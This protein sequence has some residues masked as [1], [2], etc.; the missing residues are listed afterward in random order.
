MLSNHPITRPYVQGNTQ[1]GRA[2]PAFLCAYERP[3][4][5][6]AGNARPTQHDKAPIARYPKS[7][8]LRLTTGGIIGFLA[9]T[10]PSAAV[11]GTIG[12]Y[13][14]SEIISL[15]VG[16]GPID[17][18]S[19]GRIVTLIGAEVHTETGLGSRQFSQL[20]TLPDADLPGFG[21]AFIRVSPKG[22]RLAVGNNGGDKFGNFQVGIFDAK[23]LFG[24]W[25]SASH[26]DAAW[27]NETQL[28]LTAGD[29]GNPGVVTI[30]DTTSP[31]PLNPINPIVI[32]NI[33]GASAGIAFD[34]R[35][36]LFTGNGFATSGPSGTGTV[37]FF[38]KAA[39]VAA[40]GGG[41]VL[42]FEFDGTLIV[43]VLS[44]APLGFDSFGN[45]FAGGGDFSSSDVDNAALVS[46]S[47]VAGA[48]MGLGPADPNDPLQVRRL[49]PDTLNFNFYSAN[50]N[51]VSD[52]LYVH[53]L[54]L[55]P[56]VY[57]YRVV[58]VPADS[59]FAAQVIDYSPAPG[60]FVQNEAFNDPA[61]AL[62]PPA[63]GGTSAANNSSVV[64]LGGFGGSITLAFDHTV[65]DDRA[66]PLGLDA[67]V[68]G[69]AFWIDGNAN[70]HWAE[71]GVIEICRDLNGNR[72]PDE[73]EPWYLMAGSHITDLQQQYETQT[74]DD[75]I[76]DST[77]PP[78]NPGWIPPKRFGTWQT[79]GFR[80]PPEIF[81]VVVLENP[82]GPGAEEEGIYGYADF[83]PSLILGD[84]DADD[85][86]D[87]E[88]VTPEAFYTN[89]DDPFTVGIR[90]GS[91]GGDAFDIAWAVDPGTGEP[92][93]LD[94]FDFIRITTA[95]NS[96][97]IF[98]ESSTEV[99]AVADVEP[100]L[101][102]D[103]DA[104][105][106]VDLRDFDVFNV[107]VSVNDSQ[108]LPARCR[109]MDFNGDENVDLNDFGA[110]QRVFTGAR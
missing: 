72:K 17:V 63:G 89:P 80:L 62:G 19:D 24:T 32:D 1:V 50:F 84:L 78:S 22:T 68:F 15:P 93:D 98:G 86:V 23:T 82:N 2:V 76:A 95:V 101:M 64:T 38:D 9:V 49:D 35:G 44:A 18:L 67:I 37:K 6:A 59:P 40:L 57:V 105:G 31:D 29:F 4:A 107:C 39:W 21:A 106:A 69:N 90:P 94:G 52:E 110:F 26:F 48:I 55:A 43:D 30:L 16:A 14:L 104:D 33:G 20:G 73:N 53:D 56:T 58:T 54:F 36:N 81:D 60:Q 61:K 8:L 77:Y 99:N 45:L 41:P 13:G 51:P 27:Y 74:W 87:D 46:A 71:C 47:A 70:R 83:T 100:G 103:A 92:A 102:G 109:V 66:N 12:Q 28:A 97:G 34:V 96:V 88:T 5:P 108:K 42:D 85:L 7:I 25:F 75:D 3:P 11:A 91:G 65:M 79:T 10:I